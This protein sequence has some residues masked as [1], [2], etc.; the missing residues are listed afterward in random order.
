MKIWQ[1]RVLGSL[2]LG[3]GFLGVVLILMQFMSGISPVSML[4]CTPF[5]AL[6][7]WGIWAGIAMLES[8]PDALQLNKWFWVIQIP[9]FLSGAVSYLFYAGGAVLIGWELTA[10]KV[11]FQ[12]VFGS[13]FRLIINAASPTEIGVNI[14][15]VGVAAYIWRLQVKTSL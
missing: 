1:R 15:A 8:H 11:N 6:Y 9:Y 10:T 4:I 2:A 13:Q 7:S 3:G 12:A 14:F 5:L